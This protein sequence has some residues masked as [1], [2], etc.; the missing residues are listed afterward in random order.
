MPLTRISITIPEELVQA[1]DRLA[2]G[3]D[4]SRSW[5]LVD[6]LRGYVAGHAQ[7][8]ASRDAEVGHPYHAPGG[9]VGQQRSAQLSADLELTPE[10]RVQEAERTAR[11]SE[12]LHPSSG[13]DRVLTFEH[14]A[15]YLEWDRR[16]KL[17]P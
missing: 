8:A 5:V 11:V 4:R 17:R 15:D 1:A 7:P 2:R 14:Y 10:E 16:E 9:G 6:A 3:L 13:R 12:L